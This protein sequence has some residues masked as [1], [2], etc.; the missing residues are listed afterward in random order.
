M[1]FLVELKMAKWVLLGFLWGRGG[2][3]PAPSAANTV[4]LTF[5]SWPLHFLLYC[6]KT[7]GTDHCGS[8]D[9]RVWVSTWQSGKQCCHSSRWSSCRTR[10]GWNPSCSYCNRE[11]THSLA[12]P[13]RSPP[14]RDLLHRA[15]CDSHPC[16]WYLSIHLWLWPRP[17]PK[18]LVGVGACKGRRSA[19]LSTPPSAHHPPSARPPRHLPRGRRRRPDR[20]RARREQR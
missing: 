7:T 16:V 2:G 11:T 19:P 15:P 5:T 12:R 3:L 9:N 20:F 4:R 1:V 14:C 6:S 18:E 10:A 13:R 17:E 8:S